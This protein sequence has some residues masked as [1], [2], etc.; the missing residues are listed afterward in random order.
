[1]ARKPGESTEAWQQRSQAIQTRYAYS[2]AALDRRDF[3]AAAGGFEAILK[4]EPGFLDAPHLL[5]TAREGLRAAAREQLDAGNKLD[6]AGDWVAAL[7][8]Y[9]QARQID[10]TL[11]GLRD[12]VARVQAKMH[13]AGTK[14]L[15]DARDFESAGRFADAAKE[16]EKAAQWLPAEDPNRETSRS[17]AEQLKELTK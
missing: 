13:T 15:K 17:R 2:R 11:P 16:Y 8:K 10:A 6:T 3:A 12:A 4:E 1:V 5:V 9:D 7:V 14:A